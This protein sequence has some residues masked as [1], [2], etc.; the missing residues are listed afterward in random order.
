MSEFKKLKRDRVL[1]GSQTV[2]RTQQAFRHP[3][4]DVYFTAWS[5][6]AEEEFYLLVLP[7]LFWMVDDRLARHLTF[8]VQTGLLA[9]NVMKDVFQLPRP[10]ARGIYKVKTMD[11]TGC[12]DYGFPSTHTMNALSNSGYVL[13]Y[14][15]TYH[16]DNVEELVPLWMGLLLVALWTLSLSVGRVYL[17][18]HTPTD[19]YGGLL[20][21]LAVLILH[22]FTMPY[23]DE[24]L[25]RSTGGVLWIN[26]VMFT[27]IAL[28]PQPVPSTPTFYQNTLICGI[29]NGLLVGSN[30]YLTFNTVDAIKQDLAVFD[31]STLDWKVLASLKLLIGFFV[32]MLARTVLK[33]CM[34]LGFRSILRIDARGKLRKLSKSDWNIVGAAVVKYVTYTA[35]AWLITYGCPVLFI[36]LGL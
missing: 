19:I 1:A 18:M 33:A 13:F 12:L 32:M 28:H 16:K 10:S 14:C 23:I 21:G 4:L 15:F 29:L 5:F 11:S 25:R 34:I 26:V 2:Y 31:G 9:G 20:L 22:V 8:L 6:C 35:M 24:W 27:F 7:I 30:A 36:R 17:G 3:I